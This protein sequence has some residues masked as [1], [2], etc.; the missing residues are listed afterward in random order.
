MVEKGCFD[1]TSSSL[2]FSLS[3]CLSPSSCPDATEEELQEA[4]LCAI[5]REEMTSRC[6]KL[7]CSHVFHTSCLRGWFQSQQS[8]P[9]CRM[10]V[11]NRAT[12]SRMTRAHL[13]RNLQ[14]Q[15]NGVGFPPHPPAAPPQAGGGGGGGAGPGY[16]RQAPPHAPPHPHM[17]FPPPPPMMQPMMWPGMMAPP[18]QPHPL[19]QQQQQ[20]Q[21]QQQE[22][23][24]QGTLVMH[25]IND[26][27]AQRIT[28][29][30]LFMQAV[31]VL[32]EGVVF[33]PQHVTCLAS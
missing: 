8:C 23:T 32:I 15:N 1:A 16:P 11:L 22:Q 3:P 28:L 30:E 2:S 17:M 21:Q 29:E 10:D 33:I 7:P 14:Q 4:H 27:H 5:C 19:H 25:M 18:P 12:L 6:K 13:R 31:F 24:R 26:V 9:T 20:Q